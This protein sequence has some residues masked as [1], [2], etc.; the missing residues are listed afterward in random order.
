MNV[1]HVSI[2]VKATLSNIRRLLK[3]GG[4]LLVGELVFTDLIFN[5]MTVRTLPG[6]WIGAETGQP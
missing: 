2:D 1:L 5:D 4:Y 6:R 3:P